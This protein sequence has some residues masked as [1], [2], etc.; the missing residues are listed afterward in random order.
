M[1]QERLACGAGAGA[2]WEVV[3][4]GKHPPF[5]PVC[6]SVDGVDGFYPSKGSDGTYLDGLTGRLGGNSDRN[7]NRGGGAVGQQAPCCCCCRGKGRNL[8]V[9]L[10]GEDQIVPAETIRRYLTGEEKASARWVG[11]G[12]NW[13]WRESHG[14]QGLRTR[15]DESG[16]SGRFKQHQQ[17]QQ[18]QLGEGV[19]VTEG[20]GPRKW[21]GGGGGGE[22]SGGSERMGGGGGLERSKAGEPQLEVFFYP[23]LDHAMIFDT[24]ERRRDIVDAVHRY[25][26]SNN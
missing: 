23:G 13:P 17:R 20:P 10:C 19:A 18:Q 24:K 1:D 22:K 12:P 21:G 5:A 14:A 4:G 3:G 16:R 25:V 26:N 9:V 7:N 8:T 15:F 6:A 2:A 11:T